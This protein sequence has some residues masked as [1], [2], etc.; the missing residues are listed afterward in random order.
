MEYS[1]NGKATGEADVHF[2]THEDAVAAMLK[3]RSHVR[4]CCLWFSL[5]FLMSV[6]AFLCFGVC[7]DFFL[8]KTVLC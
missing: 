7:L 6:L 3:D 5:S 1:S 8:G 2:D 4:K